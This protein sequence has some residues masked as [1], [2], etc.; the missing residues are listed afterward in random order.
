MGEKS[1]IGDFLQSTP[2]VWRFPPNKLFLEI[3]SNQPRLFGDFLQTKFVWRFPPINPVCL[4]IS[5]KQTPFVWRFPPINPVCLEISSKQSLFGDFLQSTPFVWRFPP[6][7]V[8]LEISSNQTP[9][10]WRFPPNK[11]C[12]E[13]SS[14]QPRLFGDFLQSTPFVWRFPP[15]KVCLEISSTQPR[16]CQFVWRFHQ[17]TS[18][19]GDFIKHEVCLL[20]FPPNKVCLEISSSQ[21]NQPRLFVRRF[22]PNLN[23]VKQSLDKQTNL[24]GDFLQSTDHNLFVWGFHP[25]Q[26]LD[27]SSVSCV[28]SHGLV[29][30][31]SG[32]VSLVSPSPSV[33]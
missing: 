15:N 12:L 6:N 27:T 10:V 8:C 5:S 28:M 25:K 26:S 13:I 20:R 29:Q 31:K 7:K 18:L 19:F 16:L 17:K 9:F 14:N 32:P 23:R 4:E 1:L 21:L 3:S 2:F 22:P 24:V 30:S 11:V 33:R